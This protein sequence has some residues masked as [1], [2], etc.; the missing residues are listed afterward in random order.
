MIRLLGRFALYPSA[1][2]L[3]LAA[4]A[5]TPDAAIHSKLVLSL[6]QSNASVTPRS[7]NVELRAGGAVHRVAATLP[8]ETGIDLPSGVAYVEV[9]SETHWSGSRAFDIRT[10]GQAVPVEVYPAGVVTGSV[11]LSDEKQMLASANTIFIGHDR[12]APWSKSIT[13]PCSVTGLRWTCVLPAGT[14]DIRLRV[15]GYISQ[16]YWKTAV[17]S[18]KRLDVGRAKLVRGA[19]LVGAVNAE[20]APREARP[21]VRLEPLRLATIGDGEVMTRLRVDTVRTDERGFFHIDGVAPGMYSVIATLPGYAPTTEKVQVVEGRESELLAPLHIEKAKALELSIDPPLDASGNRWNVTVMAKRPG[22]F[23][24]TVTEGEADVDGRFRCKAA[25]GD[26]EVDLRSADGKLWKEEYFTID[27]DPAR[28]QVSIRAQQIHGLVRL[29][30]RPI[31]A[32]LAFESRYGPEAESDDDGRF[33]VLVPIPKDG[34]WDVWVNSENAGVHRRLRVPAPFEGDDVVIELPGA[35]IAGIVRD[36]QGNGVENAIVT[37]SDEKTDG[38]LWMQVFAGPGGVFQAGGLAG[39]TY[40]LSAE[41]AAGESDLLEVTLPENGDHR[42]EIVLHPDQYLRGNV[43]SPYGPVSGAELYIVPLQ[44]TITN[45]FV[46]TKATGDFS[47]RLPPRTEIIDVAVSAPG[48]AH[49]FFRTQYQKGSKLRIPV[50][51]AGGTL[52]IDVPESFRMSTATWVYLLREDARVHLGM[53]QRW[54]TPQ[55]PSGKDRYTLEV[56]QM[57][58]GPY[59][60]C[61]TVAGG[62]ENASPIDPRRCVSGVLAPYGRLTL[63]L[64]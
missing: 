32:K 35:R 43:S 22:P 9:I 14:H 3:S 36:E 58:P 17:V 52:T 18:G 50:T 41:S 64:D 61:A 27:R 42:I 11:T 44:G 30:T 25:R 37:I 48:F 33:S 51:Q 40:K 7:V 54:G 39:N 6:A 1:L 24:E 21:E 59:R 19:S 12:A 29:A 46:Y 2:L 53:A 55:A 15:P 56:P 13:V 31:R 10:E 63:R 20:Q 23:H 28:F 60:L 49:M 62:I 16:Y 8:G 4:H 57:E 26:Y 5:A 38:L 47:W 45:H 34:A